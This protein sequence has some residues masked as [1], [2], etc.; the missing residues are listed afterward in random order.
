MSG[1]SFELLPKRGDHPRLPTALG[2]VGLRPACRTAFSLPAAA[3][4]VWVVIILWAGSLPAAPK[5]PDADSPRA[6]TSDAKT[7]DAKTSDAAPRDDR[8]K[9]TETAAGDRKTSEKAADDSTDKLALEQL[10]VADRFKHLEDVLLRMAELSGSSDPRRAALLKKAVGQSKEQ[11]IDIQFERLVELLQKDQLSRAIENQQELDQDLRALLELLLSENR[12]QQIETQKKLY[13]EYLKRINA[14][15]KEQ[16]TLQGRTAGGEK[17]DRLSG[18]QGKLAEKTGGLAKEFQGNEESQGK[19]EGEEKEKGKGEENGKGKAAAKGEGK[20]KAEGKAKANGEGK[21]AGEGKAEA[22]AEAKSKGE[23]KNEAKAKGEG[24]NEG[25][26]KGEGKPQGKDQQGKSG[27]KGEGKPEGKAGENDKKQGKGGAKSKGQGQAPGQD[28]QPAEGQSEDQAQSQEDQQANP[29]RK[30]L[31]AAQDRM[32]QAEE[33]LKQAQREGAVDKQEEALRELEQAKA[34]LEEIL[35]QLR[36][37]EIQRMLAMLEARCK[38]MLQMQREVY[39]ATVRLDKASVA[40]R[41]QSHEIEAGRLS[42]KESQIVVEA[43]RVRLLLRED[44]SA[45]VFPEAMEQAREDMQ[46]VV[47]RLAQGK[48]EQITQSIE[49]DIIA[50]LEE[51][52]DAL[53]K[54]QK[55]QEQEQGKKKPPRRP[56]QENEPQE[57]PL[58]DLL[59][60]IKLIRA[61]QMRV[62][63]RTERYS[64]LIDGEQ[65]DKADLIQALQWLAERQQRIHRVTRDLELGRNR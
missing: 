40:E 12:A 53:K 29:A 35:R 63:T 6:K 43:D 41:S 31:Q 21:G 44:G 13:Q 30:R 17:T 11:L 7:S 8:A 2:G 65:A 10:R 14:I 27:G 37:E 16:K 62:N 61:M 55:D 59:A 26:K 39:D 28:Q 64:K 1:K 48:V 49:L 42:N 25:Q 57:R 19:A 50:A 34:A 51:M 46:Q 60:E 38:K 9:P 36:Q 5:P 3:C 33:K 20:G 15:I 58:V 23:G 52:V 22:K 18:E 32:Q 24:K 47:L 56:G 54:A 4:L 45:V